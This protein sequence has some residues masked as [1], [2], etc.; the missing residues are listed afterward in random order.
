VYC[1]HTVSEHVAV[2]PLTNQRFG[3]QK[4]SS[5]LHRYCTIVS[6][7]RTLICQLTDAKALPNIL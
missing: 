1:A 7:T 3:V 5:W 4:F 6:K 2:D